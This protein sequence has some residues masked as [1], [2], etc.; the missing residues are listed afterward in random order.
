MGELAPSHHTAP[1]FRRFLELGLVE[2]HVYADDGSQVLQIADWRSYRPA[3]LTGQER[4]RHFRRQLYGDAYYGTEGDVMEVHL[5]Q[6]AAGGSAMTELRFDLP[7]SLVETIAEGAAAI[8]LERL[9][10]RGAAAGA[11]ERAGSGRAAAL[12]S[13]AGLRPALR[14]PARAVE[15]RLAGARETGRRGCPPVAGRLAN[16][17]EKGG[18]AVG[19]E[20]SIRG[21]R[22][23]DGSARSSFRGLAEQLARRDL[24]AGRLARPRGRLSGVRALYYGLA[25]SLAFKLTHYPR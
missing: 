5:A 1:C 6:D 12:L 9:D 16:S 7:D 18:S 14:R 21:S 24:G 11:S 17:H 10:G 4:K 15:G 25:E 2:E 23:R 3:D 20:H 8:V 13:P 19:E 22:R